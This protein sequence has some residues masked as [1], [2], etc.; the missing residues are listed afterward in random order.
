MEGVATM[1]PPGIT[2]RSELA[3]FLRA[4]RG[5]VTPE[6]AG[7]LPGQRRRTPGLRREEVA[8]LAGV[9][10]TWYTWLEQGRPINVSAQ[11]LT[12]I[13][14]ALRLDR[15][16]RDHLFRLSDVAPPAPD[17]ACPAGSEVQNVLDAMAVPAM[18]SNARFDVLAWNAAWE[19][20]FPGV[21]GQPIEGRNLLNCA[22]TMPPCCNPYLDRPTETARMV[23]ILRHGYGKNLGDPAWEEF[24]ERLISVSPEFAQLWARQEVS[25]FTTV[26]RHF[27]HA[28]VGRISFQASAFTPTASPESRLVAY[29]PLDDESRKALAWLIAHPEASPVD[30]VH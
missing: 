13:A 25:A 28:A 5:R 19:A 24:V 21:A 29:T 3:A 2:K 10:V 9:G 8:Q 16:Q 22:F 12:A 4:H 23:A 30:H 7:L 17:I 14:R 1:S 11:V 26:E 18:L 20:I 15:A 27:R 6:S